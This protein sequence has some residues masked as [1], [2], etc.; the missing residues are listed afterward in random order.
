M[1]PTADPSAAVFPVL[2]AAIHDLKGP[3]AHVAILTEMIARSTGTPDRELTQHLAQAAAQLSQVI[4][5]LRRY[6]EVVGRAPNPVRLDLNQVLHDATLNLRTAAPLVHTVHLPTVYADRV[7]ITFVFEEILRNA[8][9]FRGD[10]EPEVR[11][12]APSAESIRFTDNGPGI[13]T[14]IAERMF[15]PFTKLTPSAGAGMGL[16][17]CRAA[18]QANGGK[19]A[20]EPA[21]KGARVVLALPTT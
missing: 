7:R 1:T 18:L 16:C 2:R 8:A 5:G 20:F 6:S 14:E 12:E 19:I 9:R 3:A 21:D 10:A 11:I 4:E 17:I 15:L 13:A